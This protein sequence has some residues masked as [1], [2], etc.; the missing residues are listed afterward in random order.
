MSDINND[1]K[2]LQNVLLDFDFDKMSIGD[3]GQIQRK[4]NELI[5]KTEEQ[6][7]LDRMNIQVRRSKKKRIGDAQKKGKN[8]FKVCCNEACLSSA[9]FQKEGNEEFCF[10]S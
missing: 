7:N 1:P 9:R 10:C 5:D 6:I 4:L 8:P 2:T 3:V